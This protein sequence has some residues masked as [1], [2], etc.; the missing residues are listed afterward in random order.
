MKT[1]PTLCATA[2]IA[3]ASAVGWS[4]GRQVPLGP[5]ANNKRKSSLAREL[6]YRAIPT[7]LQTQAAPATAIA[8]PAPATAPVTTSTPAAQFPPIV[9]AP[10][11]ASSGAP[12]TA[13]PS[14]DDPPQRRI[15]KTRISPDQPGPLPGAL[16]NNSEGRVDS[17]VGE[18][19][20]P[21]AGRRPSWIKRLSAISMSQPSSRD[22][23]P[24]PM[25]P[26]LSVSNGSMAFSHD[27]STAP[28]IGDRPPPPM[29]PNKLV[30]RSSSIHTTRA[31][32]SHG[33][34]S[35]LPS[36]RRPATSHQR[37]ATIQRQSA[38]L[39]MTLENPS[40][41]EPPR[42]T[43]DSDLEYTQ[44]FTA[45]IIPER[46]LSKR[47]DLPTN[48]KGLRR[49]YPDDAPKPTLLLAKAV[50]KKFDVNDIDEC[51]SEDE[52]SVYS[53][54]RPD[55]PLPTQTALPPPDAPSTETA[56][57][58][59]TTRPRRSFSLNNFLSRGS[60]SKRLQ[61]S[62]PSTGVNLVRNNS[63]RRVISDP[64]LPTVP[65][66]QSLT[67]HGEPVAVTMPR[68]VTL[69]R[70]QISTSAGPLPE[71]QAQ[72]GSRGGSSAWPLPALS[73][74]ASGRVDR[75]QASMRTGDV[76]PSA[77][78]TTN[79]TPPSPILAHTAGR[80][81]RNSMAP[82]EQ[83]STL[84]GSD[85]EAR[86]MG[87][88]DEDDADVQSETAFD[89]LRTGATRSTSGA[90]GPR[91]E[92]IFD[93]SPP[94]KV[95]V[96]ALRDLLPKGTF[97]EQTADAAPGHQII[98]EEDESISTPV[99][100]VVPDRSLRDSPSY[101]R[102]H[103]TPLFPGIISSSPPDMPK[104]LS[105]G[106]L[107]WDSRAGDDDSSS[108]WSVDEEDD[109][110]WGELP[111]NPPIARVPTPATPRRLNLRL[112]ASGP[113]PNPSTPP[114]Q[115]LPPEHVDKDA[116]SSIFDWSEQQH[117]DKG[118][119]NCTPP[120]PST[121]HGKKDADRRGSR[122][123]GRR[124]P[125]GLHARSQSVPVVP[126]ATGKRNTVVTNKFGTWGVGSKG[127]TE[128]WNDDFDF[129]DLHEE[130]NV[131][132][133]TH[134]RR[135]DSGTAMLVPKT[136]Q[137]QQSNVL[138]N[139]GLLREWGLLI[140]ELK[141]QRVRA[142]SLGILQ[143]SHSGTWEEVD[144]MI[145]LADQEVEHEGAP[146]FTPPSSPFLDESAFDDISGP[147][148]NQSKTDRHSSPAN[149]GVERSKSSVHRRASRKS[150]LRS[151]QQLFGPQ[152]SPIPAKSNYE[153][154][155]TPTPTKPIA[156]RPRKDSEAKARSVI[157]AL[158]Q[159]R[160]STPDALMN[161]ENAESM[162]K[163][164]FDTAT[165]RRIVPYVSSLTRKVKD[166][167]REAEGLYS[168]PSTSPSKEMEPPFSKMFQTD[169]DVSTQ[170]KLMTVM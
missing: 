106:T 65:K 33:P 127:V 152:S 73:P 70:R 40:T 54:G 135:I 107:E 125:S 124:A 126:D 112:L 31:A 76:I 46:S 1:V 150:I 131:E 55:S 88:G 82:S 161:T 29:P 168:S 113:S 96:T 143:G 42:R 45:K 18:L 80:P 32:T 52:G 160:K 69:I 156:N 154:P 170:M 10:P 34:G 167:L 166:A 151:H 115:H 140:E 130:T 144:A 22:T 100:T 139:I 110:S 19:L 30:K 90:R 148:P 27:G 61:R 104:P 97:R 72:H 116:R 121:V 102:G 141:E 109:S 95:K 123:V 44:Y 101:S 24:T 111:T 98:A 68:D 83:A 8:A 99:R 37:S 3:G 49:I 16:A 138:A 153:S 9:P 71:P 103:S 119:G 105:L 75:G 120:R 57:H 38:L 51:S 147:S 64:P 114:S 41:H 7:Q 15:V 149:E 20:E 108:R 134:S 50:S 26:S 129:S 169:N 78:A 67:A 39:D 58:T 35:R 163:V 146:R 17:E 117:T 63:Q 89:S 159:K 11:T 23:S 91:I 66:R 164:P 43:S 92:T 94:S 77:S 36:F 128:D 48:P 136:I 158:Q 13:R 59:N 6:T 133:A 85:N 157:E 56:Q 118:S 4:F 122:S 81:S 93:E 162:S 14:R 21:P 74:P 25:S 142:A 62:T 84:V 60:N 2:T 28:M 155:D 87:T 145:D 165:L 5:D 137:E 53:F 12:S 132:G 86:G 79:H 47:K